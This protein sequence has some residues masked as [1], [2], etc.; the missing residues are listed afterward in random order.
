MYPCQDGHIVLAVVTDEFWRKLMDI[1][2]LPEIDTEE[3]RVR[4]GRLDNRERIN[5]ELGRTLFTRSK[6][7][8]LEKLRAAGIP[9]GPVNDF[10]EAFAEP[11]VKAR[12]MVIEVDYPSG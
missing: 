7:Y 11:Q 12:N 10:T 8:W 2:E 9:S 5:Q 6:K 1:L 3:N 4:E